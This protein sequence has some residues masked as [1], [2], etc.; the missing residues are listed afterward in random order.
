[1]YLFCLLPGVVLQLPFLLLAAIC[2]AICAQVWNPLP[3]IRSAMPLVLVHRIPQPAHGSAATLQVAPC[4]P[5]DAATTFSH[6]LPWLAVPAAAL[7]LQFCQLFTFFVHAGTERLVDLWA[8]QDTLAS[9]SIA[10]FRT[11]YLRML[12]LYAMC[13]A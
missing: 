3:H 2:H 6:T 11:L 10:A 13:Y 12:C 4:H 7:D 5:P 9:V 1:V 8:L